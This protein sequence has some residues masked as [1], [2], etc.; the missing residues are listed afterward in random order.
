MTVSD[1][2]LL[3]R[4]AASTPSPQMIPL[5]GCWGVFAPGDKALEGW[6]EIRVGPFRDGRG[7]CGV[8][9][10]ADGERHLVDFGPRPPVVM[11]HAMLAKGIGGMFLDSLLLRGI[12]R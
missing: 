11:S 4:W 9:R 3:D 7:W 8:I 10:T 5:P 1:R 2:A 12:T 6:P